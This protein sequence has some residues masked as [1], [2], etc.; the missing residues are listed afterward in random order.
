MCSHDSLVR[1]APHSFRSKGRPRIVSPKTAWVLNARHQ[2]PRDATPSASQT[3]PGRRRRPPLLLMDDAA[4]APPSTTVPFTN[5]ADGGPSAPRRPV[6]SCDLK[7]RTAVAVV[8]KVITKC[9]LV[10]LRLFARHPS[11]DMAL[12]APVPWRSLHRL[13]RHQPNASARLLDQLAVP[14]RAAAAR[15][16]PRRRRGRGAA[17]SSPPGATALVIKLCLK[18]SFGFYQF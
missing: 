3:W 9:V 6:C 16:R 2:L 4:P 15:S 17:A 12:P 7:P 14:L 10:T 18:V 11:G 1:V 13:Q 5:S 8:R